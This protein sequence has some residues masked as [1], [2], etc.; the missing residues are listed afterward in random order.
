MIWKIWAIHV[1]IYYPILYTNSG[2]Q[3]RGNCGQGEGDCD[4]DGECLDGLFCEFD[5]WWGD[6]FCRAGRM[7]TEIE[8]NL[9]T[10]IIKIIE[11]WWL[12]S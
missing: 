4:N 6:D 1:N 10:S 3:C 8:L 9:K 12:I 5:G 11:H 2:S 7:K